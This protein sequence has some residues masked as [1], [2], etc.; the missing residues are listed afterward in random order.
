LSGSHYTPYDLPSTLSTLRTPYVEVGAGIT[1]IFKIA[2]VQSVWRLTERN[3][4]GIS[5]WGIVIGIRFN[6]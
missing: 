4:P 2:S 5:P 1:N 3:K 6:F